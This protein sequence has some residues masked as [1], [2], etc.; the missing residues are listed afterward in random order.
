MLEI[1][2]YARKGIC[3]GCLVQTEKSVP[4]DHYLASLGKASLCQT[5]TLEQVFLSAL[6][7]HERFL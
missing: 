4:L 2:R 7:T 3:H 5:M 1:K 6:Q